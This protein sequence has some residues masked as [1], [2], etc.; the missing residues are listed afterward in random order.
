MTFIININCISVIITIF[1]KKYYLAVKKKNLLL[2]CKGFVYHCKILILAVKACRL[3][4]QHNHKNNQHSYL[5]ILLS[6]RRMWGNFSLNVSFMSFLRSEGLTYSMT[7]VW[8]KVWIFIETVC[9][10][11]I[12]VHTYHMGFPLGHWN[13]AQIL[14]FCSGNGLQIRN[15]G[16]SWPC[17]VVL[18]QLHFN[19]YNN[20]LSTITSNFSTTIV[21][22]K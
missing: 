17:S 7:V 13:I 4:S 18:L 9:Q 20:L 15:E 16:F 3:R 11:Y 5:L 8:K 12:W 10:T 6:V 1:K 2:W 14:R 21:E 22:G 19:A